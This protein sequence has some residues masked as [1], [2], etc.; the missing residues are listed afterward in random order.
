MYNPPPLPSINIESPYSNLLA[1]PTAPATVQI[2]YPGLSSTPTQSRTPSLLHE[3]LQTSST[4]KS[5]HFDNSRSRKRKSPRNA[6]PS[7]MTGYSDSDS[8]DDGALWTKRP[9]DLAGTSIP[10]P[11]RK[12]LNRISKATGRISAHDHEP[13][14]RPYP[15]QVYDNLQEFFPRLDLDKSVIAVSLTDS[16]SGD[17][18]KRRVKK[19]IRMVAEEQSN[20]AQ[21]GMRRRTK[22]WD[23]KVE[24]LHM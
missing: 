15:A 10:S 1:P 22:F 6:E 11:G 5:T 16:T 8:G 20:R 7:P 3:S 9:M 19:S 14:D 18:R 12:S 4:P 17:A 23:S 21:S 2:S 13:L 24:E